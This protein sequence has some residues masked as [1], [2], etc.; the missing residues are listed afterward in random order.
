MRYLTVTLTLRLVADVSGV[1]RWFID[2][3]H[4]VHPDMKG[5][6]G[7]T[8]TMGKDSRRVKEI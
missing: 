2:A 4:A 3:S 6:T 7:G 1:I 8:M 5:H